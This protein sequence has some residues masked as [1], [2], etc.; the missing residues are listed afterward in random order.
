M[1]APAQPRPG[2]SNKTVFVAT[3]AVAPTRGRA[4]AKL[5]LSE[6]RKDMPP[7]RLRDTA[8]D[9]RKRVLLRITIPEDEVKLT[10]RRVERLMGRKPESRLAL[11]GDNAGAAAELDV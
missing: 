5:L 8:M 3:I 11:I 9:A 4:K 1:N 6:R 7:S 2:H 10:A